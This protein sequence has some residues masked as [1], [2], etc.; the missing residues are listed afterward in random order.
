MR[1][2]ATAFSS[3][4]LLLACGGGGA[5]APATTAPTTPTAV[6]PAPPAAPGTT[7][8]PGL[9]WGATEADL[10]ARF[11]QAAPGLNTLSIPGNHGGLPGVT[12][13]ELEDGK[14]VRISVSFEEEYPGMAECLEV[15]KT[16]R[17]SLN[18]TLGSSS[19]DNGAAYWDTESYNITFSCDP[20]DEDRGVLGM[21]YAQPQE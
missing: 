7:G 16:T 21:S 14:L 20:G 8:Y 10:K 19:A 2:L 13:F 3:A 4:L 6:D 1:T 11:P 12:T 5:S 15:W 9:D 17:A 18:E